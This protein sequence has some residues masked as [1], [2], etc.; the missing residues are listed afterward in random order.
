MHR[1]WHKNVYEWRPGTAL[2]AP[3]ATT[4]RIGWH[5]ADILSVLGLWAFAS[6]GAAASFAVLEVLLSIRQPRFVDL[7]R[8]TAG[9]WHVPYSAKPRVFGIACGIDGGQ[10]SRQRAGVQVVIGGVSLG[11][12]ALLDRY[13]WRQ[14]K[15]HLREQAAVRSDRKESRS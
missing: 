4:Y 14:W 3:R 2:Y 13:E 8:F 12:F 15:E 11:V 9:V 1:S 10:R 6:V 5:G 7:G